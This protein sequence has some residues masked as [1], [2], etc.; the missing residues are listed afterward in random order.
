MQQP[1]VRFPELANFIVFL[2]RP[3]E[4]VCATQGRTFGN[5]LFRVRM[6]SS[7]LASA[8]A[9]S[10]D[11]SRSRNK[12]CSCV[13]QFEFV[14]PKKSTP[15]E[16]FFVVSFDSKFMGELGWRRE[17]LLEGVRLMRRNATEADVQMAFAESM[18]ESE[19]DYHRERLAH[20][21]WIWQRLVIPLEINSTITLPEFILTQILWQATDLVLPKPTRSSFILFGW[22]VDQVEAMKT[23]TIEAGDIAELK[24][25]VL[26]REQDIEALVDDVHELFEPPSEEKTEPKCDP[27]EAIALVRKHKQEIV[28][29]NLNI[30]SKQEH[31]DKEW[32]STINAFESARTVEGLKRNL[33]ELFPGA[34]FAE[35]TPNQ[36]KRKR[37]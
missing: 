23:L 25:Q 5:F 6:R 37:T 28:E 34:Q 12:F 33:S 15:A 2:T 36:K 30:Q 32:A 7:R 4:L 24:H 13:I 3:S 18:P 35:S 16:L 20:D 29:L 21:A 9:T 17:D 22:F 11:K 31:L 26:M 19:K 10:L 27:H 8:V 1:R 14:G